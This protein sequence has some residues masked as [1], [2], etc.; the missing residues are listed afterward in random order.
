MSDMAVA[1]VPLAHVPTDI[2]VYAALYT[3]VRNAKYLR[4]QLLAGNADFEYAFVEARM[5]NIPKRGHVDFGLTMA[6]GP[7]DSPYSS[8]RLSSR[9]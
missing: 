6:Q 1:T 7:L 2:R 8:R 4:D 3:D 9:E 5:V